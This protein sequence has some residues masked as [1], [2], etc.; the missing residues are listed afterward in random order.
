MITEEELS[1]LFWSILYLHSYL[2]REVQH[3][4]N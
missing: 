1:C 2:N 4:F 3:P